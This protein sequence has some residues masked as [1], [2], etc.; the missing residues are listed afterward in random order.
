MNLLFCMLH[1]N[2]RRLWQ[3]FRCNLRICMHKLIIS[4]Q[5][6]RNAT[7]DGAPLLR[8]L[9]TSIAHPLHLPT[10][11]SQHPKTPS[12]SWPQ[13]F[14]A[15][16]PHTLPHLYTTPQ[17]T[18]RHCTDAA[19]VAESPKKTTNFAKFHKLSASII[20]PSIT[21]IVH[22]IH[23]TSFGRFAAAP[24]TVC[25]TPRHLP[26]WH[27]HAYLMQLRVFPD[28]FPS[29]CIA[30]FHRHLSEQPPVHFVASSFVRAQFTPKISCVTLKLIRNTNW[31]QKC[32]LAIFDS[33]L[34]FEFG[35]FPSEISNFWWARSNQ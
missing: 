22:R 13:W 9:R 24:P 12:S 31:S 25:H 14:L 28:K 33:V 16:H 27:P 6:H 34:V 3:L 26:I 32:R 29:D 21:T 30:H 23:P 10:C 11:S 17:R 35:V 4:P 2:E 1:R 20:L 18:A 7:Y 5:S 19:N 15:P 8:T